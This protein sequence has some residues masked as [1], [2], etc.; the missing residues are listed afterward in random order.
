M[1]TYCTLFD[2]CN[3]FNLV[4][5][6]FFCLLVQLKF[7]QQYIVQHSVLWINLLVVWVDENNSFSSIGKCLDIL[8]GLDVLWVVDI[9]RWWEIILAEQRL[10]CSVQI[11]ICILQNIEK[12]GLED[13]QY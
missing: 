7:V 9:F 12:L 2:Q 11:F 5:C 6:K 13:V 8:F 3:W 10:V 4:Q 1:G